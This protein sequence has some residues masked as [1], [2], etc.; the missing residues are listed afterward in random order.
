MLV[1]ALVAAVLGVV[2][3]APGF[4]ALMAIVGTPALLRTW[5]IVSQRQA[6]HRET[7]MADALPIFFS[8]SVLILMISIVLLIMFASGFIVGFGCIL[9]L[10]MVF[11]GPLSGPTV[12]A[13]NAVG[14]LLGMAVTLFV[15]THIVRVMWQDAT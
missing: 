4:G 12:F 2:R 5:G 1:V 14:F 13:A 9:G 7:K 10:A 8:S 3:A 6:N 11:V 15:G